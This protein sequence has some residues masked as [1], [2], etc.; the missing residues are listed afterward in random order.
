MARAKKTSASYEERRRQLLR[1]ATTVF[2]RSGYV[3]SRVGDI[4]KEAGVAYGL[5]YHY[6]ENKEAILNALFQE[7]WGLV[8]KVVTDVH[9]QGGSLR[10]KLDVIAGFLMEAWKL[11]PDL[12]EVVMLEVVR[13]PKFLEK[14]NVEAFV[15]LL[16]RLEDIFAHHQGTGEVRPEVD[17]K[18]AAILLLG[19][20]EVLLTGFVA[21]EF[22]A[23]D[24]PTLL[25]RSRAA[26]VDTMLRGIGAP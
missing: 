7:N 15:A 9:A 20:L 16:R 14:A 19:Q 10:D 2:A 17:P 3:G 1:A 22:L 6:F 24:D 18:L 21:K 11:Q 13:S 23:D 5:V 12:V 25:D 26:V 8:L 4:A